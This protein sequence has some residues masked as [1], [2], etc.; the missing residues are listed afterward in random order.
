MNRQVHR[1]I[2]IRVPQI[3]VR[4]SRAAANPH[5]ASGHRVVRCV[6]CSSRRSVA[7]DGHQRGCHWPCASLLWWLAL[8]AL[9]TRT[10]REPYSPPSAQ[11]AVSTYYAATLQTVCARA[12]PRV[13]WRS[14]RTLAGER[15]GR[16]VVLC[17]LT[18]SVLLRPLLLALQPRST[19]ASLRAMLLPG[20]CL[21]RRRVGD[22]L[23]SA[24]SGATVRQPRR[25]EDARRTVLP[26]ADGA[27]RGGPEPCAIEI[28]Q[29]RSLH[30]APSAAKRMSP[31]AT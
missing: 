29:H 9:A 17:G 4:G 10:C 7:A 20:S 22:K 11:S 5:P 28:A 13:K 2:F 21:G 24:P 19:P 12:T 27:L 26:R 3:D 6:S 1:N 14:G 18:T 16:E 31:T 15:Q 30:L 8:V 23:L 25:A